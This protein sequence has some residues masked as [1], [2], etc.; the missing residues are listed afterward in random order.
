MILGTQFIK[1]HGLSRS[2][3]SV[4]KKANPDAFELINGKLWIN[5]A[6]I[7]FGNPEL[8]RLYS[9]EFFMEIE[10]V[11]NRIT[12][13]MNI[14]QIG[15]L[16]AKI[17]TRTKDAWVALLYQSQFSKSDKGY[18]FIKHGSEI[19]KQ[20]ESYLKSNNLTHL[21]YDSYYE[22]YD[23]G[24]ECEDISKEIKADVFKELYLSL[25]ISAG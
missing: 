12:H 22:A 1:Q 13:Y 24:D 4:S 3:C 9:P 23:L 18:E 17:T 2:F 21:T 6:M 20:A 7:K 10:D 25:D 8:T 5:P 14:S 15:D 19:V 11:Y 16:L